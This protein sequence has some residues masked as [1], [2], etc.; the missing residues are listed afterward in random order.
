[1]NL[2]LTHMRPNLACKGLKLAYVRPKL[3]H[4]QPKLAH[5][6]P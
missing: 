1:M 6:R 5:L 3:A 4:V 2:I